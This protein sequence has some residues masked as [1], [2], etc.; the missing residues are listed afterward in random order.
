MERLKGGYYDDLVRSLMTPK[1]INKTKSKYAVLNTKD[2]AKIDALYTKISN[3]ET[4]IN[5]EIAGKKTVQAQ[6]DGLLA[7][8]KALGDLT[9]EHNSLFFAKW[10]I[11]ILFIF[12]EIAPIL[13]K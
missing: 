1:M 12:I 13:F 8:L 5:E 2:Y 6:N 10:L 11:T 4:I 9:N 7:R 3:R